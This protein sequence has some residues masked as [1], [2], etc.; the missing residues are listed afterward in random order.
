[1]KNKSRIKKAKVNSSS[2][3]TSSEDERSRQT[4]IKNEDIAPEDDSNSSSSAINKNSCTTKNCS[5][6]IE[7]IDYIFIKANFYFQ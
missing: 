7:K 2:T 4:Y 6:Y 5:H 3:P 1:M